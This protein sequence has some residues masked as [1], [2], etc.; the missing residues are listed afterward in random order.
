MTVA[1]RALQNPSE[2]LQG[3]GGACLGIGERMVMAV[4]VVAAGCGH[5][6]EL[7]VGEP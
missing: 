7:M 1:L 3:D 6:V 5:Y 2:D 4:E